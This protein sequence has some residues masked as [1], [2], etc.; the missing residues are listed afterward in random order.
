[1]YVLGQGLVHCCNASTNIPC[2]ALDTFL[3]FCLVL[4]LD[5]TMLRILSF[6]LLKDTSCIILLN[7]LEKAPDVVEPFGTH[8]IQCS[9]SFTL[10]ESF[11]SLTHHLVSK[12]AFLESKIALLQSKLHYFFPLLRHGRGS[13][14]GEYPPSN[15]E[16]FI[17]V[18]SVL[19]GQICDM[20][21]N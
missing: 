9:C 10:L 2:A 6:P 7:I 3:V 17:P 18:I 1:M 20:S 4:V 13:V 19:D 15:Q 16:A 14:E 12:L 8:E 5:S 11:N 21:E